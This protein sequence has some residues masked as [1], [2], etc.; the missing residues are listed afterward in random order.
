[1]LD[2]LQKPTEKKTDA[3]AKLL[4]ATWDRSS[5]P[6]AGKKQGD[7]QPPHTKTEDGVRHRA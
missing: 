2:G 4:E 1:M 5:T 3:S 6:R 7:T